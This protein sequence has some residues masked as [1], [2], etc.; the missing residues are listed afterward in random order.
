MASALGLVLLLILALCLPLAKAEARFPLGN[1]QPPIPWLKPPLP[2][3]PLGIEVAPLTPGLAKSLELEV[4]AGLVVLRVS[5]DSPADKAGIERKD[6]I[7]AVNDAPV[8]TIKDFL[9]ALKGKEVVTLKVIRDKSELNIEITLAKPPLRKIFFEELEGIA[10]PALF[11]HFWGGELNILDKEGKEHLLQLIPGVVLDID[12]ETLKIDPNGPGAEIVFTI[13]TRTVIKGIKPGDKVIVVTINGTAEARRVMP[14][15]EF[16]A[17]MFLK[18]PPA[19]PHRRH[20][21]GPPAWF[22]GRGKGSGRHY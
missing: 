1:A 22:P 4:I 19:P 21:W 20:G 10:P 5:P 3:P 13:T 11:F 9:F 7:I 14:A 8:A 6:I 15:R 2:H 18:K 12:K 17:P 16:I